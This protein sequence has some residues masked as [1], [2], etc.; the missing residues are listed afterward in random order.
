MYGTRKPDREEIR[1]ILYATHTRLS[2]D[3][4]N[5]EPFP[6]DRLQPRHPSVICH[7]YDL[8]QIPNALELL[9]DVSKQRPSGLPYRIGNKYPINIYTF[10]ELMKWLQLP[11][12]GTC[13][14]V[15]YNGLFTDEEIIAL[16]EKPIL[17]LRQMMYNVSYN[18]INEDDFI[19][20]VLPKFYLQALFLRSHGQKILLNIDTEFFKTPELLNLMKLINCFYGRGRNMQIQPHRTTLYGYCAWKRRAYLELLP[21]VKF[22]VT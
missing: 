21:W 22:S 3:G 10:D 4:K 9:L 16:L 5:L 17:G 19:E 7:D 12:M 14:F 2:L 18:C 13:F 8:A 1:T 6:Y 20:R 15:Q 11:P